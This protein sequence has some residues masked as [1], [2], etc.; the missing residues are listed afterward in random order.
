MTIRDVEGNQ[1]CLNENLIFDEGIYIKGTKE[2]LADGKFSDFAFIV[3]G[4]EVPAHRA[5]LASR[6]E[7]F[8]QIFTA[9]DEEKEKEIAKIT[10][11]SK[12]SLEKFLAYLYTDEFEHFN[13]N[14]PDFLYLAN[15]FSIP[16]VKN[17]FE[18]M[19]ASQLKDS[20]AIDTYQYVFRYDLNAELK[21]NA[22][23]LIQK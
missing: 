1:L 6:S 10:G 9:K 23:K 2:L 21:L 3:E 20:N 4:Q 15:K 12:N 14:I 11:A 19:L 8:N 17:K 22:F 5:L 18:E 7:V 13:D 16:D